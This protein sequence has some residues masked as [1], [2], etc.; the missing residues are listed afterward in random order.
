[1][2]FSVIDPS[3]F[4]DRLGEQGLICSCF[5]VSVVTTTPTMEELVISDAELSLLSQ[6][7]K[8]PPPMPLQETTPE[9]P[10]QLPSF[11]Q[12]SEIN[13]NLIYSIEVVILNFICHNP[14]HKVK[15]LCGY[16]FLAM[17]V[18]AAITLK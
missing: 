18:G 13:L 1:M 4:A 14:S 5:V 7:L 11:I 8:S 17:R 12:V 2:V 3:I 10:Q 16:S 6:I 15:P 9:S